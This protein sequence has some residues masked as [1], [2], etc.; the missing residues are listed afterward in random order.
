MTVLTVT[1]VDGSSNP[2]EGAAVKLWK[3][4]A[5]IQTAQTNAQGVAIID[6]I[7]KGEYGVSVLKTG[8]QTREFQF[9][10]GPDCGPYSKS[11]TLEP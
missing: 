5:V 7:C 9:V 3:N 10:I 2:I 11:L 1:V 4:G 8:Y 6:G